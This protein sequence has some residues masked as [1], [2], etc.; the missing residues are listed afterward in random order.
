M[1]W[2]CLYW[3]ES[4]LP[5]AV[6]VQSVEQPECTQ[7]AIPILTDIAPLEAQVVMS[8]SMLQAGCS[9]AEIKVSVK[10]TC[11][12]SELTTQAICLHITHQ[13]FGKHGQVCLRR[14]CC[15]LHQSVPPIHQLH[16]DQHSNCNTVTGL[17]LH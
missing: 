5:W 12:L 17:V 4:V 11:M 3:L 13:G 2:H 15:D 10:S 14:V 9:M 8:L 6:L 7:E 16:T 1:W